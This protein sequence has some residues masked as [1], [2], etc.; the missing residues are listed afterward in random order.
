MPAVGFRA[1]RTPINW[2]ERGSAS[3]QGRLADNATAPP[4]A[5]PHPVST[6]ENLTQGGTLSLDPSGPGPL[7]PSVSHGDSSD[8]VVFST[9][10]MMY[11]FST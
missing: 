6:P 2:R 8:L 11:E 5:C 10:T 1:G 3:E 4:R 9:N 7:R